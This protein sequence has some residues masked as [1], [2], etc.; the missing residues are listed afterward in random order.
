MTELYLIVGKIVTFIIIGAAFIVTTGFAI[1]CFFKYRRIIYHRTY[2]F[3]RIEFKKFKQRYEKG[4]LTRRANQWMSVI[5]SNKRFERHLYLPEI[6][7]IIRKA[8]N[9][10]QN[11]YEV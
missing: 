2:L 6:L 9:D 8:Q 5:R 1:K 10:L 4:E 3:Q 7:E 11:E